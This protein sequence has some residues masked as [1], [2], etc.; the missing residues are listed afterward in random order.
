MDMTFKAA[1]L[2]QWTLKDDRVI[3][4]KKEILLS[5]LIKATHTPP[6]GPG[7][8]GVIQVFYGTGAFDFATLAYPRKESENG[9][10]AAQYILAAV[11]GE[12][13]DQR[14]ANYQR[15]MT[16]GFR[17][18]CN[19]CG[20]IYCY[21]Y[22]DL[23]NNQRLAKSAVWSSVAGL[24]GAVGG[25][26]GASAV[27]NQTANDQLSR[28]VD[29]TKCPK[30]GSKDIVDATDEDIE[31][32]KNPQ[33]AV[34]QQVSAADEIKKFKELLDLGVITQEE[35]DAKKKQLLGL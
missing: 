28:I 3:V 10:I 6:K 34:V 33:P 16:E 13:A 22:E 21:T 26:Y 25:Y 11:T 15:N 31:R 12:D 27:N 23:Q 2:K 30:C 4:G 20:H 32:S 9:G 29:Y 19:V 5:S 14:I 18:K 1:M 17:K 24:G 7:T 8:N 35:F